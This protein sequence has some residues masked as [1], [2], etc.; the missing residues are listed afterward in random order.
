VKIPII[1]KGSSAEKRAA[2]GT[3][4]GS[5]NLNSII[6]AKTYLTMLDYTSIRFISMNARSTWK[7]FARRKKSP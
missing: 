4:V 6:R 2:I 3:T 5:L 7:L 1:T